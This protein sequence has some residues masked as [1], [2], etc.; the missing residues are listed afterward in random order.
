[1][2]Y[3][4]D[5][6]Q[7]RIDAYRAL[8]RGESDA[9]PFD[10]AVTSERLSPTAIKLNLS[11][12]DSITLRLM[13]NNNVEITD[14]GPNQRSGFMFD[15]K[16]NPAIQTIDIRNGADFTT[17]R[18]TFTEG[19]MTEQSTTTGNPRETRTR[20]TRYDEKSGRMLFET[21]Q[22]TVPIILA[23]GTTRQG[24]VETRITDE[25]DPERSTLTVNISE[26]SNGLHLEH[27][28]YETYRGSGQ[29]HN[30][31]SIEWTTTKKDY[32]DG[33]PGGSK[34]HVTKNLDGNYELGVTEE[35]IENGIQKK[36]TVNA[37]ASQYPLDTVYPD[38]AY[39][40]KSLLKGTVIME[41]NGKVTS[42]QEIENGKFYQLDDQGKRMEEKEKV[43]VAR[44]EPVLV[45][46]A[47]PTNLRPFN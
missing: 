5:E 32:D 6:H 14:D 8:I 12:E 21:S 46:A 7:S 35:E 31:Q 28:S 33:S 15:A 9:I 11:P 30:T 25:N 22:H 2:P 47:P 36:R 43:E 34:G 37:T 44:E 23:G 29:L 45:A 41:E 38:P 13:Q 17:F 24:K 4:I 10:Q 1:M 40:E 27:S 18:R 42:T 20:Q 19:V 16:N 39:N 3:T 26:D